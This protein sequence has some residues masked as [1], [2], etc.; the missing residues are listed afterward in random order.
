M[1]FYRPM[2]FFQLFDQRFFTLQLLYC[3]AYF[4]Y[5]PTVEQTISVNI[6]VV[7]TAVVV[8]EGFRDGRRTKNKILFNLNNVENVTV[9][10][11]D[12]RVEGDENLES[13]MYSMV[14]GRI[15][16]FRI[17]KRC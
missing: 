3:A 14:A 17:G 12:R 2:V 8:Q 16:R 6:V 13:L 10:R 1:Q 4:R 7:V 11:V 15:Q 5:R 9:Y